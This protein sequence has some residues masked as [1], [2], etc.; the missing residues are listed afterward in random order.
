[1]QADDWTL[2]PDGAAPGPVSDAVPVPRIGPRARLLP[3][4][5]IDPAE[6][7]RRRADHLERSAARAA[8]RA[9]RAEALRFTRRSR[10]PRLITWGS[11]AVL[12]ALLAMVLA[13]TALVAALVPALVA[14]APAI[15]GSMAG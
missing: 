11:V 14:G 13:P 6:Q 2:D 7:A 15:G 9:E 5:S 8:R 10:R 12:T 3:A 4:R 1:M